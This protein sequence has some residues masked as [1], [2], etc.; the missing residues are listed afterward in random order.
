MNSITRRGALIGAAALL[1]APTVARAQWPDRPVRILV[2]F[3]P[4]AATDVLAR[5]LANAL[6]PVLGQPVVV[7]NRPGAGGNIATVAVRRSPPDGQVFLAHSVAY[8]VNPSLYRNAGYDALTDLEPVAL[9]ASTPNIIT[10]N[11]EKLAVRTLPELIAAARTRP[12]DYGSSGTGT[13][14]HLGMEMLFRGLAQV[15][16]QHVPFGRPRPSPPWSAARCRSAAHP[17]RPRCRWCAK[18]GCA[19]SR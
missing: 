10:V 7:E 15:E 5:S 2:A 13:T 11:P 9:L 17:C 16:V 8:A 1:A 12:L 14:T 3:P 4:G 18:A 6:A 19:A